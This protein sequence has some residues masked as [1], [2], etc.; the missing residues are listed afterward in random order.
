[1]EGL[2][3]GTG[4]GKGR[5]TDGLCSERAGGQGRMDETSLDGKVTTFR[6]AFKK[7][8]ADGQAKRGFVVE[9]ARRAVDVAKEQNR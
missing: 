1:L 5:E 2:F 4:M 7:I 8:C 6:D 9:L 3:G